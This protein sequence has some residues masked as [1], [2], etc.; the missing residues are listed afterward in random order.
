MIL[1]CPACKTRYLVPDTAVG[2]AGR[3]VRCASCKHRWFTPGPAPS[4]ERETPI[5]RPVAPPPESFAQRPPP[6]IAP[7]E[8]PSSRWTEPDEDYAAPDAFAHEPPF[9]PRRNPTRRW[10]IAAVSA[11]LVLVA[12]IVAIQYLGTPSL[13]ARLG[14]PGAS[15]DI[16]LRLAVTRNPERRFLENGSELFA[17][18]GRVSNPT[19]SE[20]RV[21]DIIA[22]LL[23]AQGRVVYSWKIA[24]PQRTLGPKASAEF[25]S[26]EVGVP[27]GARELKLSFSGV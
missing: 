4:V 15:A 6:E 3:Q 26:A 5:E 25:N 16:P 13:A 9:R 8:A 12:G 22:E 19:D 23:S 14:L 18:T 21:P 24:P 1:V 7:A 10:T 20:Q 11:A 27:K 17:V 2:R